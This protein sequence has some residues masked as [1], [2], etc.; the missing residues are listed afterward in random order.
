[1]TYCFLSEKF[2]TYRYHPSDI[3]KFYDMYLGTIFLI[4]CAVYWK[5]NVKMLVAQSCLTLCKPMHC[6]PPGSSVHG[7]L[8]ARI[9]E[10]VAMPSSRGSSQPRDWTQVSHIA[11]GFLY[12]LILSQ[13]EPPR[14]PKNTGMDSLPLLQ[15][16]FLTQESNQIFCIAGQFFTS[17]AINEVPEPPRKPNFMIMFSSVAQLCLT[18]YNPMGCSMSGF[19]VHYQLPELAHRVG[20]A[21]QPSHPLSSPSP[22]AFNLS[23]HQGLGTI[24]L[25]HFAVY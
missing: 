7:I 19:P 4:H 9:L 20:D 14:K 24:F 16:I 10:R 13:A 25:I 6:S 22:P 8:Q 2:W 5:V 15:G 17:W 18:L 1:M 3:L 21:I 23:Q 12:S 11:G